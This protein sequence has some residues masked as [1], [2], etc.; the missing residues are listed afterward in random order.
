MS[1]LEAKKL[2]NLAGKGKKRGGDL[3]MGQFCVDCGNWEEKN[4]S[5]EC[6]WCKLLSKE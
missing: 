5:G 6:R 2:A 1:K 3:N 4:Y